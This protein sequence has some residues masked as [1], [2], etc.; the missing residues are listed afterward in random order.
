M[1]KKIV[2]KID[3]PKVG[4]LTPPAEWTTLQLDGLRREKTPISKV[5]HE[6]GDTTTDF[7]KQQ[8]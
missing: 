4:S 6:S 2:T 1:P 8:D 7:Q 3:E 5:S